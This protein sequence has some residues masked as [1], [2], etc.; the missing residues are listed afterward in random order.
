MTEN[1]SALYSEY[2]IDGVSMELTPAMMLDSCLAAGSSPGKSAAAILQDTIAASA[3]EQASDATSGTEAGTET[4]VAEIAASE[5]AALPAAAGTP[6]TQTGRGGPFAPIVDE[7]LDPELC[8]VQTDS[9]RVKTYIRMVRDIKTR[10]L[11]KAYAWSRTRAAIAHALVDA[12]WRG[13]HFRLGDLAVRLDWHWPTSHIGDLAAFYESVSSAAEYIDSLGLKISDYTFTATEGDAE[14]EVKVCLL[15]PE[16]EGQAPDELS[17]LNPAG[18][19]EDDYFAELA[20]RPDAQH[21]ASRPL[22]SPV[23]END[24]LPELPFKTAHPQLGGSLL[25]PSKLVPDAHSWL[26]YVPFDDCDYRLAGSLLAQTLGIRGGVA[27]QIEDADYFID[28]YEVVREL[29]EDGIVLS[30]TTVGGGGLISAIKNMTGP[31]VGA[32]V[33]L[34]DLVRATGEKDIIRLLFSEVPGVVFQIADIDYDYVDAEL[35]LQDVAFYPLGHPLVGTSELR[36]HSSAKSGI[37]VILESL[38]RSQN[39]EGED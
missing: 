3:A 8:S 1:I 26:I 38:I 18:E 33:E 34:A 29:V 2:V 21:P 20:L 19:Y 5:T 28:C 25:H 37:Q 13:G 32:S 11:F 27:P 30:G 31:G 14:L 7:S 10:K 15:D 36:V 17:S 23:I 12:V 24:I 22:I 35:L 16:L 6:F 4:A 39:S 9:S